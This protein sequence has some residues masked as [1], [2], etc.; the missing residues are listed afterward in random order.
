MFRDAKEYSNEELLRACQDF[1][2]ALY[3][4]WY[5]TAVKTVGEEKARQMLIELSEK[6]AELE[7]QTMHQLWGAP[8]QNLH[9]ITRT[10]D[11][12]HRMVAYEGFERGS[13]PGWTMENE[14]KGYEQVG[15][16][17]IFAT[18]P[19]E[20]KDKGATALCTVYCHSIGQRFYTRMGCTIEQDRW[21]SKGDSYCGFKIERK[22]ELVQLAAQ[23][24]SQ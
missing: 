3:W 13:T 14:N 22:A 17:P 8:F 19:P 5:E 11:V 6:F 4:A 12:I 16:C 20:M 9:Q 10:L 18:T 24:K 21:L 23:D 15:H 2:G 1:F 7:A